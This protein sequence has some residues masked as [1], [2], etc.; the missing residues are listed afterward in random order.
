MLLSYDAG[1]AE[2]VTANVTAH[3]PNGI[4]PIDDLYLAEAIDRMVTDGSNRSCGVM[5]TACETT[6]VLPGKTDAQSSAS[7][8]LIGTASS[9]VIEGG[10]SDVFTS[11]STV[12]I[13]GYHVPAAHT[14]VL[15]RR[16]LRVLLPEKFPFVLVPE[17]KTV[18]VIVRTPDKAKA[19]TI[20]AE[21]KSPPAPPTPPPPPDVQFAVSP[22]KVGHGEEVTVK[23]L[24]TNMQ[25]AFAEAYRSGNVPPATI[26]G[27][28]IPGGASFDP[29]AN[30]LK[31]RVPNSNPGNSPAGEAVILFTLDLPG[32][33]NTVIEAGKVTIEM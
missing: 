16:S 3:L 2:E 1:E 30:T 6:L 33:P 11:E 31:F 20:I 24:S 17:S 19:F 4:M 21:L 15:G 32:T 7:P 27:F 13:G 18:N 25:I 22:E 14:E 29:L 12:E 10:P 8:V 28:T 9:V 5:A 23:I 26:D